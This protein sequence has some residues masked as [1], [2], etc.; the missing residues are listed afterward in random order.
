MAIGS[1][2]R[3]MPR[4]FVGGTP[5]P[6]RAL[7]TLSAIATRASATARARRERFLLGISH[8]NKPRSR[9]GI[10]VPLGSAL[11]A[12]SHRGSATWRRR[13]PRVFDERGGAGGG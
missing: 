3:A 1:V 8:A 5:A 7:P 6:T 2:G 4:S 10:G 13:A 12:R 9:I 11:Y